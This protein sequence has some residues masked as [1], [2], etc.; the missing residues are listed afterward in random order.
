MTEELLREALIDFDVFIK[1]LNEGEKSAAF[2]LLK[3]IN[4]P[5]V[6]KYYK[7]TFQADSKEMAI[8]NCA[9]AL[10]DTFEIENEYKKWKA[11]TGTTIPFLER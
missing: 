2:G 3:R 1:L 5:L 10:R 11:K 7:E 4:L 8:F 9:S 6:K